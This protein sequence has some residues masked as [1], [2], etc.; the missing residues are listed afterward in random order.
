MSETQQTA[1]TK[2]AAQPAQSI[3]NYARAYVVR[4]KSGDLGSLP[5]IF[6]M[7]VI[8]V[9]FQSA[10]ENFL[11]P[12]NF[13]NLIVQMAGITTIAIGV[14]FVLLLGE[15]DLSIGYV[16]AVAAVFL[17]LRLRPPEPWPWYAAVIVALAAVSVIGIIQGAIITKFRLPS[18]VV[19]LAGLLVWNGVVLLLIGAAGTVI[20][21][22]DII[23][24]IANTFLP[25]Q[26]GWAVGAVV[27]AFFAIGR[28]WRWRSR[29][30]RGVSTT[31]PIVLFV[32]IAAVAAMIGAVVYICNA[33]RGVPLV[34]VI[35]VILLAAFSFL[36]ARTRFG[37]YVYAVGGNIEAA[38]RAGISVD[39][40]RIT[41]FM[42]SSLMAGMG[43]L[44]LASRLRSVD[45]AAGG[46]N[47]LLIS[48][49]APVIGG[50]SLFGGRGRVMSALLGALIIAS[51]ENGMGLL[52]LSAGV[53]FVVTGLVLLAA[54]LVDAIT[55]RGRTQSG[56]G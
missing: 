25:P 14:V 11:T 40:V 33:D 24:G 7:I 3:A 34:G 26:I 22:D 20:I 29:R 48:I 6:G 21:Q 16:S 9:I 18:F 1:S 12:R 23:V 17:A 38:R 28:A 45:T 8:A 36:A 2:M 31:P 15:I 51:V 41:V 56:T 27:V 43:G 54:V 10:N 30:K 46:G 42:I 55:R 32:Q 39:R 44:I 50:T 35:L 5:I 4:M 19:T 37:R 52:G 49:A 53:K 13:V 47:L